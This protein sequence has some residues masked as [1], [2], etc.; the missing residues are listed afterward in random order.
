MARKRRNFDLDKISFIDYR[1][2]K[3]SVDTPV[4]FDHTL[5][6]N[7]DID[8][9][10]RLRINME[11]LAVI[12]EYDLKVKTVS[13]KL[14]K[15]EIKGNFQI[16]FIFQVLNLKDYTIVDEDGFITCDVDLAGVLTAVTY[17]TARGMLLAKL[18]G[19]AMEY[20]VLPIIDPS[21]LLPDFE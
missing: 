19:T 7:H 17:S 8:N 16:T 18:S 1:I 11:D 5:I 10:I 21:T 9:G 4:D 2:T 13:S 20:F 6:K 15:R 3:F 14:N 12:V